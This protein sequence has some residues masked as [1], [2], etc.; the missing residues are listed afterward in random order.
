MSKLHQATTLTITTSTTAMITVEMANK[1][2]NAIRLHHNIFVAMMPPSLDI[3]A[4]S[5]SAAAAAAA[6][7]GDTILKLTNRSAASS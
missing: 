6:V 2:I 7:D 4:N 1:N 3:R 5:I